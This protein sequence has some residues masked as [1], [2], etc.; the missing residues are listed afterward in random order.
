MPNMC[1]Q[2]N[3][4]NPNVADYNKVDFEVTWNMDVKGKMNYN[5]SD[6][7]SGSDVDNILC[8]I[9]R[10]KE[11]NMQAGISFDRKS[12]A[13]STNTW[14]GFG[15]QNLSI[16]NALALGDQDAL[17][18]EGETMDKC[19]SHAAPNTNA[20]HV[21]TLS[22]CLNGKSA[23]SGT[24]YLTNADHSTKKPGA[25]NDSGA[26]CFGNK[27]DFMRQGWSKDDATYGGVYGLAMDGHVIYGPFN[28]AGE[29]W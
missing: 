9:Q 18:L 13:V 20:Q 17:L 28:K 23:E 16:F 5:G 24:A 14:S 3:T 4:K 11:S 1:W 27:Y 26:D 6:F 8:D 22:P 25:C 29:V 12:G 10:T 21:H 15:R 2:T 7:K 19:L